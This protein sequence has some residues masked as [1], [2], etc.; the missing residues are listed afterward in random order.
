MQDKSNNGEREMKK[1]FTLTE[2]LVVVAIIGI[3][4]AIAVPNYRKQLQRGYNEAKKTNVAL[5]K[6]AKEQLQL[7]S[8]VSNGDTVS[9][10]QLKPF[11]PLYPTQSS[12]RVGSEDIILGKIGEDPSYPTP[13]TYD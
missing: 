10:D 3:I 6:F 11:A 12:L 7:E 9:W 2:L 4:A 8:S 1:S 13:P 5:V